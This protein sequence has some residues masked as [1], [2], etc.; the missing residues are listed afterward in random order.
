M[1]SSAFSQLAVTRECLTSFSIGSTRGQQPHDHP[2]HLLQPNALSIDSALCSRHPTEGT[3]RVT[4]FPASCVPSVAARPFPAETA[5]TDRSTVL[6]CPFLC[7]FHSA[8]PVPPSH[9]SLTPLEVPRLKASGPWRC[10]SHNGHE[11]D[12]YF[13]ALYLGQDLYTDALISDG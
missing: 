2:T 10:P 12:F 11:L 8:L 6:M 7:F 1:A 13:T 3:H 5:C 4:Y 9:A